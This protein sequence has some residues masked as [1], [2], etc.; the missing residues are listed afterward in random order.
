MHDAVTCEALIAAP[1]ERVWAA[2]TEPAHLAAW[3]GDTAEID[4]RRG[5]G[6]RFGWRADEVCT[7]VVVKV[8]PVRRFAFRW[9]A[10]GTIKDPGLYTRV[11]FRLHRSDDATR[12]VVVESGFAAL[13]VAESEDRLAHV[14]QEHVDGWRNE[15][16]DLVRYLAT[17]EVSLDPT[18]AETVRPASAAA[19][20]A[21]RT[22]RD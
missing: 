14:L 12:L 1:R 2:L 5:G 21:S 11:D 19:G 7:G 9:D 8:E 4:L 18:G 15:I 10:F 16:C 20:S 22:A 17:D 6:V 13:A 3:F